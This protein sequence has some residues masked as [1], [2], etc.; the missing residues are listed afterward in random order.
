MVLVL[1]HR[2]E[3][4]HQRCGVG[5]NAHNLG[6]AIELG[7]DALDG[8]RRGDGTPGVRGGVVASITL[9]ADLSKAEAKRLAW[10]SM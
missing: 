10:R 8:V 2:S 1:Q 6:A 4:T 3:H 5:K 9:P 7:I